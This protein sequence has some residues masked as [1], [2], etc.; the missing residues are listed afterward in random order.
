[1]YCHACEEPI[2]YLYQKEEEDEKVYCHACEE[3]VYYLYQKED[4]KCIAMRVKNRFIICII[5]RRKKCGSSDGV[6]FNYYHLLSAYC[7]VDIFNF[8]V[9]V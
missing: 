1:M 4:K 6:R 5:W 2:Y 3:P 9:S 8:A 7:T